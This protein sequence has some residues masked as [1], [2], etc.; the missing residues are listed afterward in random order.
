[1][2]HK[3]LQEII[4]ATRTFEE[5][6][7]AMGIGNEHTSGSQDVS[8]L[9]KCPRLPE[10]LLVF[11]QIPNRLIYAFGDTSGFRN[12]VL[13]LPAPHEGRC[14]ECRKVFG[15]VVNM[16]HHCRTCARPLC[17]K[18][19][20]VQLSS[21]DGVCAM[22]SAKDTVLGP[23]ACTDCASHLGSLQSREEM[24]VRLQKES[25]ALR[26]LARLSALSHEWRLSVATHLATLRFAQSA[27]LDHE[28]SPSALNF[29]RANVAL[30]RKHYPWSLQASRIP[31]DPEPLFGHTLPCRSV[32]CN[33]CSNLR[34]G[35]AERLFPVIVSPSKSMAKDA[36][37]AITADPTSWT[38]YIPLLVPFYE[39][40]MLPPFLMITSGSSAEAVVARMLL[41]ASVWRQCRIDILSDSQTLGKA[42]GPL[43]EDMM[44]GLC[45]PDRASVTSFFSPLHG[46]RVE[47]L[48]VNE[49]IRPR[50][51]DTAAKSKHLLSLG[52]STSPA[53]PEARQHGSNVDISLV[54]NLGENQE[55]LRAVFRT[56]PVSSMVSVVC[57]LRVLHRA[58]FRDLFDFPMLFAFPAVAATLVYTQ[59]TTSV[60][61][62]EDA[63]AASLAFWMLA[64]HL[65]SLNDRKIGDLRL[66]V[67]G[68]YYD[69]DPRMPARL[70]SARSPIV[71]PEWVTERKLNEVR[72][73]VRKCVPVLRKMSVLVWALTKAAMHSSVSRAL[74]SKERLML[75]VA[76]VLVLGGSEHDAVDAVIASLCL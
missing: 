2:S 28:L 31:G 16:R 75:Y 65:F 62:S 22:Y 35:P 45:G 59:V 40:W 58:A 27:F 33:G 32:M 74:F 26:S 51:Q 54:L 50:K 48:R 7:E 19:C 24:T 34:L 63:N 46:R 29:V 14:A 68:S 66:E 36:M 57:V 71:T 38:G 8:W 70:P 69:P 64:T 43:G 9:D 21:T 67:G 17:G 13:S 23:Y 10:T 52:Q 56:G 49:I 41:V 25:L 61:D 44:S 55:R 20:S 18:C 11:A 5:A 37:R 73:V 47:V 53:T 76:D 30:L 72:H 1:M 12:F 39:P 3:S 60:R 6:R 4:D 15:W 42:L